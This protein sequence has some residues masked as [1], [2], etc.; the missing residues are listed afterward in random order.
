MVD[1]RFLCGWSKVFRALVAHGF[2]VVQV[3]TRRGA[4]LG[5]NHVLCRYSCRQN[6]L[7][8]TV[9]REKGGPRCDWIVVRLRCGVVGKGCW[10]PWCHL[11]RGANGQCWWRRAQFHYGPDKLGGCGSLQSC[12]WN[13]V[14]REPTPAVGEVETKCCLLW[15]VSPECCWSWVSPWR[16]PLP[17]SFTW[18]Q[19]HPKH[20]RMPCWNKAAL[21]V[22][23]VWMLFTSSGASKQ[24]NM[25]WGWM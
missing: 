7:M 4:I 11:G 2:F 12:R 8:Y 25:A 10:Y 15:L 6:R 24:D 13:K 5:L 19:R 9:S 22:Q 17:Y 14:F 3:Q 1:I 18:N 21:P 20:G 23:L 16:N